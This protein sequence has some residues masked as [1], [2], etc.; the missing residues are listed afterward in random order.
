MIYPKCE[1]VNDNYLDALGNYIGV[2]MV[3]TGND[4]VLVQDNVINFKQGA[5][6]L[7]MGD[8]NTNPILNSRIY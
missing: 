8:K 7:I 4:S 1:N 5:A 3:V 6:S 2:H